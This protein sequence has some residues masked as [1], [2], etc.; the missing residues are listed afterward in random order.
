[1]MDQRNVHGSMLCSFVLAALLLQS[2]YSPTIGV[3]LPRIMELCAC[4]WIIASP[5]TFGIVFAFLVGVLVSWVEGSFIGS[6]SIGLS[7]VAYVLL[8]NIHTIRQLDAISQSLLI[9]LLIG[10]YLACHRLTLSMVGVSSDGLTY[11]LSATVSALVWRP[12]SE[13][14]DRIRFEL[15]RFL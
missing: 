15:G 9:F 7:L 14:L 5:A 3:W 2:I 13:G 1:M 4:Y 12:L 8:G 11:L 6:A 10:I